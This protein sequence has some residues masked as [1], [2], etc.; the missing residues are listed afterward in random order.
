ML[1]ARGA[2]GV[3]SSGLLDLLYSNTGFIFMGLIPAEL[4]S[5]GFFSAAFIWFIIVALSKFV[6]RISES[7]SG[8]F[9]MFSVRIVE[10]CFFIG[11][12][13]EFLEE[14]PFRSLATLLR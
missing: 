3:T 9:T 5:T 12:Y 6:E 4:A 13:D 7:F 2:V 11:F 8:H 10:A 14:V 1:R